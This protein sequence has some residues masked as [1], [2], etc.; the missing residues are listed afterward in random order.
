MIDA[1]AVVSTTFQ[2]GPIITG[3]LVVIA[4]AAVTVTL[5][6]F[7]KVGQISEDVAVL[8][9][10]AA[11][12]DQRIEQIRLDVRGVYDTISRQRRNPRPKQ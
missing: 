5:R 3:L 7:A 1:A 2:W 8:K 10:H 6:L 9:S 11:D 4:T 12:A